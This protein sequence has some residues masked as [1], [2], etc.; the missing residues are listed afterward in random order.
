[1]AVEDEDGGFREFA[2]L[3]NAHPKGTHGRN[4]QRGHRI[5]GKGLYNW[6]RGRDTGVYGQGFTRDKA[7]GSSYIGYREGWC[8]VNKRAN[9]SAN[10]NDLPSHE[11]V[12]GVPQTRR[13]HQHGYGLHDHGHNQQTPQILN[14]GSPGHG[15]GRNYFRGDGRGG[16]A[17]NRFHGRGYYYQD[18][19]NYKNAESFHSH[20]KGK[21][22]QPDSGEGSKLPCNSIGK[23]MKNKVFF[24]DR[25]K[26]GGRAHC[27]FKRV[28]VK[29][30]NIKMFQSLKNKFSAANSSSMDVGATQPWACK[31]DGNIYSAPLPEATKDDE[32]MCTESE[33]QGSFPIQG[34]ASNCC[35][36]V[37]VLQRS[38]SVEEEKPIEMV[39]QNVCGDRRHLERA[40]ISC[41]NGNKKRRSPAVRDFP[42]RSGR[43][44]IFSMKKIDTEFTNRSNSLLSGDL[45][46][47]DSAQDN[48]EV[49]ARSD[50]TAANKTSSMSKES[51][52][53]SD[54]DPDV[55]IAD[56]C[57]AHLEMID[58]FSDY[59]TINESACKIM[60]VERNPLAEFTQASHEKIIEECSNL[61]SPKGD[62]QSKQVLEISEVTTAERCS[63][64]FL[65]QENA[66][67]EVGLEIFQADPSKLT[68]QILDRK[69]IQRFEDSNQISSRES[70]SL[71]TLVKDPEAL[72][73][74]T[75]VSMQMSSPKNEHSLPKERKKNRRTTMQAVEGLPKSKV[76]PDKV[77]KSPEALIDE[78]HK[79]GHIPKK[80]KVEDLF[81]LTKEMGALIPYQSTEGNIRHKDCR[82]RSLHK[83]RARAKVFQTS[84]SLDPDDALKLSTLEAS[85]GVSDRALVK[86]TLHEF[87]LIRKALIKS[88][89]AV[90]RADLDAGAMLREKGKL[91]N[92]NEKIVGD[93][94]GV[95]VGDQFSF[96][97]E[98]LI[99]G[100]H[101]QV[102][103]GIDYIPGSKRYNGSPLATSIVASGGYE[104][105]KDD[106]NTLIYSGQGGNNIKGNK[107]QESNQELVRG[108]LALSNS[109]KEKTPVRVIRGTT[110]LA[111]P[112]SKVYT[113]DGLYDVVNYAFECGAA[114]FWVYQF[115]LT[116]RPGQP[117]VGLS[118]LSL[119]KK[120]GLSRPNLLMNDISRGQERLP[121]CV[122][123]EVD[124]EPAPLHFTYFPSIKYPIWYSP[125]LPQGCQCV[126]VCD[127]ETCSCAIKNGGELPYNEKGYLIRDKA[128]VY[129]CGPSCRCSSSCEN[130]VTQKGLRYRLEV[131]KTKN[132]GWGVRSL[133]TIQM[134]GFVCEYTGELL[135]DAEAEQRIGNDEYLFELGN[136]CNPAV[137][138][139]D[140][141]DANNS[142][143]VVPVE[144]D[145]AYT[146]DAKDLG[147]VARFINHSCSPN[148]Y[149]Q[150]V[151]YDSDDL[152][153]PHVMLIAMERIPPMRELTYD[154]HYNLDQVRDAQGNV[155]V[156]ACYCGAQDCQGR[157]Y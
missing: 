67:S 58:S 82:K 22:L 138:Q 27:Y 148:L 32:P 121:V 52:V 120:K 2:S 19:F 51:N 119:L 117:Q 100:L 41:V 26:R 16:W 29:S 63:R 135:S 33:I 77:D 149:A 97:M 85:E 60:L 141:V 4:V 30:G 72:D 31:T 144:E 45:E 14:D 83:G 145:I 7:L 102:Q 109:M 34:P 18:G 118:F 21:K 94:P 48:I 103:S 88:Q 129:E 1:M 90:K 143:A 92:C 113:Y 44:R 36:P 57:K 12:Y 49:G 55:T 13:G 114:G 5:R 111:S 122:V 11:N 28:G 87:E 153:F 142:S 40:F 147:N 20:N 107:K 80:L 50:L 154:Y 61:T 123:N 17:S 127:E 24:F 56:G 37:P 115:T 112:S 128:V 65:L 124:D 53:P 46:Q 99:I 54:C 152:R 134:G 95:E 98:M 3:L 66:G 89:N 84:K 6:Q 146:I 75:R 104:D 64:K 133:D 38:G 105:D 39:S 116:R 150:N 137:V 86:Q 68:E 110:D 139:S 96:R 47:A 43:L 23:Q 79:Q 78:V 125:L 126:G 25:S 151:L 15:R 42:V 106:G 76:Q 70:C 101:R 140:A 69:D 62:D 157:L 108:N 93:V 132:R 130:R 8:N 74:A 155:K 136:D 81:E 131:F 73:V 10:N 71:L 156:K 59:E 35:S 91:R 9:T